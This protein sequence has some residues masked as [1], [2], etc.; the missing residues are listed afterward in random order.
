M[1][2]AL[3][4]GPLLTS[5]S[6][7]AGQAGRTVTQYEADSAIT[8]E[9]RCPLKCTT[10][11]RLGCPQNDPQACQPLV[12]SVR[13]DYLPTTNY[14]LPTDFQPPTSQPRNLVTTCTSLYWLILVA[15]LISW[16]LTSSLNSEAYRLTKNSPAVFGYYLLTF[17]LRVSNNQS[18]LHVYD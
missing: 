5:K 10:R 7:C 9:T 17:S 3:T 12:L 11:A 2:S 15:I 6:R 1:V 14:Q 18:N 13:P 4:K 8:V 16:V